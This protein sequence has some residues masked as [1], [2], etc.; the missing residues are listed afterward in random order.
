[1]KALFALTMLAAAGALTG[2]A[3]PQ[4]LTKADVDGRVICNYD[5][6]DAVERKARQQGVELRWINCPRAT[7]RA[8]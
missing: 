4:P 7:L 6:M 8:V 2:C 5:R 3:T 1:M